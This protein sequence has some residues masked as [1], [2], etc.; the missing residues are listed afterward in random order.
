M[1]TRFAT[2]LSIVAS[3][4]FATSSAATDLTYKEYKAAPDE[5]K[6]GFVS[7][8]S[9]YM[10]TVAQPDEEPPYPVRAAFQRCFA[11]ATEAHLA[12]QV[13]A[14]VAAN[15]T[16]STGPVVTVVMR[17]MFDLCRSDIAK[18]AKA[19]RTAPPK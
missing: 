12:H 11:A 4:F 13:D 18:A 14:Y 3:L 16:S 8:I 15:P 17:A 6:R 10:S 2:K 1:A 9:R 5:W 7:G 19:Q